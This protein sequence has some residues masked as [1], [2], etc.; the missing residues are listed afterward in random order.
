MSTGRHRDDAGGGQEEV[1]GE[2]GQACKNGQMYF[3]QNHTKPKKT[4][5]WPMR[6]QFRIIVAS[7]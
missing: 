7:L 4:R 2:T 5:L 1:E 6:V 3:R